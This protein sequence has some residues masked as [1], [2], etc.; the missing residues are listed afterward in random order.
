MG[1]YYYISCKVTWDGASYD[2]DDVWL[3]LVNRVLTDV[4]RDRMSV[5]V[6]I[7]D[8]IIQSHL[9]WYGHVIRRDFKSQIVS[10]WILKK[11]GKG[12]RFD[13]GGCGNSV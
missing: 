9:Q 4:L 6:K 3:R 7:E 11:L 13:Q 1:T 8:M 2:Q 10:S 5:I 12:K